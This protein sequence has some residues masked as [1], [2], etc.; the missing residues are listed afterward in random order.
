MLL[1]QFILRVL[2]LLSNP[3]LISFGRRTAVSCSRFHSESDV[4]CSNT[5]STSSASIVLVLAQWTGCYWETI[6]YAVHNFWTGANYIQTNHSKWG[7]VSEV[8]QYRLCRYRCVIS[9]FVTRN[10]GDIDT[11]YC[12]PYCRTHIFHYCPQSSQWLTNILSVTDILTSVSQIR[13][14]RDIKRYHIAKWDTLFYS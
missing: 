5:S 3:Q 11:I 10:I 13:T 6:A 9:V 2:R 14:S 1:A 7:V 8:G 4:I 12:S